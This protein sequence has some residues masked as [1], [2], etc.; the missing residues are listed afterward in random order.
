MHCR[1][2]H[3]TDASFRIFDRKLLSD[4]KRPRHVMLGTIHELIGDV[5]FP[6][7]HA[8]VDVGTNGPSS[9][10]NVKKLHDV[11]LRQTRIQAAAEHTITGV[12]LR[13]RYELNLFIAISRPSETI[14]SIASVTL[15][16]IRFNSSSSFALKRVR[17]KFT[18]TFSPSGFRIAPLAVEGETP[19]RMRT[20]FLVFTARSI[21]SIPLCPPLPL[22]N[23]S[24]IL[25]SGRSR[26]S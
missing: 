26:S 4:A 25:P 21:D 17:M 23:E 15:L 7:L 8:L 12:V 10:G 24:F 6:S 20:N 3:G 19:T 18:T 9:R 13:Q 1:T 11:L 16:K 14:I 5:S 2:F 22:S